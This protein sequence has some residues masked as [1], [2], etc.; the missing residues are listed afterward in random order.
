MRSIVGGVSAAAWLVA[1]AAQAEVA[2]PLNASMTLHAVSNIGSPAIA[3]ASDSDHREWNTTPTVL[4]TQVRAVATSGADSV[5]S[6]ATETATWASAD[7]GR[8]QVS[9][10]GHEFDVSNPSVTQVDTFLAGN[11]IEPDW[12]YAFRAKEDGVFR[13][14]A[15]VTGAGDDLFGL[16]RWQLEFVGD[17][18]T[19]R[20]L[21]DNFSGRPGDTEHVGH[22]SAALVAGETYRVS[23]INENSLSAFSPNHE[24]ATMDATF[25]WQ[26][27]VAG[28]VPEPRTW[29]LAIL[30]FGLAGAALRRKRGVCSAI[31]TT[32]RTNHTN[33]PC[34]TAKRFAPS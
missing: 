6:H 20:E 10:F 28:G 23:L 2:T 18:L 27:T 26:V 9:D 4:S 16:G 32:N 33:L 17:G 21:S 8:V 3:S 13:M 29:T 24:H 5:T 7:S 30:G 11:E 19:F 25:D 34:R 1:S 14:D 12:T 31:G 15:D 22:F